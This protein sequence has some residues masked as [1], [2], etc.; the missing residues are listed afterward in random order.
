M[1]GDVGPI[2]L[3][4]FLAA[5]VSTLC[6]TPVARWA[7]CAAGVVDCP[8][9]KR[10][11]QGKPVPLLGGVALFAGIALGLTAVTLAPWSSVVE[12]SVLPFVL[13]MALLCLLGV[14]D[15]VWG[16]RARWKVLAQVA[17]ILPIVIY[18]PE[19]NSVSLCGYTFALGAWGMLLVS[20]WMLLGINSINLI[21]G[22]DGLAS[23]TGL[24]I[25]LGAA[26]IGYA[27]GATHCMILAASVAGPLIGFLVY[28]FPPASIYMGD[29]GSMVI[30]LTVAMLSM[31]I[32]E[33]K[34]GHWN[35]TRMLI[36][37]AVP[38][39]DTALAIVRR[40]LGGRGI[41]YPDRGHMHHRMLD[42]GLSKKQ[43]L[44]CVSG[45]CIL[46]SV[47]AGLARVP[48][49]EAAAW[50]TICAMG[51]VLV[52]AQLVGYH[53]WQLVRDRVVAKLQ[54]NLK[55]PGPERLADMPSD[56]VWELLVQLAEWANLSD[57]N[58]AVG[59]HRSLTYN[60]HW[61][62]EHAPA[63]GERMTL[64]FE[65]SAPV[66]SWC[67]VTLCAAE[68]RLAD[69]KLRELLHF[70]S[71]VG[72]LWAET[73]DVPQPITLQLHRPAAASH[74]EPRRKAA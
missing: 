25:A 42:R 54:A 21:D 61:V 57:M 51:V 35:L 7:A 63:T 67:T 12:T 14:C 71:A 34:E 41:C 31:Q 43:A 1:D 47:C 8:D 56:R 73:A 3:T 65:H 10:K 38:V 55:L 40:W 68:L 32:A 27:T 50:G 69:V 4:G 18:G 74:V 23:V 45:M 20:F 5:L 66:R 36:L 53:E 9:G 30:G 58:V 62:A 49:W 19:V 48:G 24:C 37:M 46:S 39:G 44:A 64:E 13:S 60:R 59:H 6:L 28:N 29:A 26:A 11:L 72:R 33:V 17:A 52:R 16:L 22:M 70:A 15:D 2:M